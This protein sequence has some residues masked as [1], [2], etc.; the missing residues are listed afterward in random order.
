MPFDIEVIY[1]EFRAETHELLATL[2]SELLAWERSRDA[3]VLHGIFRT[4]HT[5]KGNAQ[6]LGFDALADLA[7]AFEDVLEG[8]RGGALAA[9]APLMALLLTS[10][11]AL[12]N[13]A[14]QAVE[15][16]A[17]GQPVDTGI[18][19]RLRA[20]AGGVVPA[21]DAAIPAPSA[22]TPAAAA[23]TIRVGIGKLDRMMNLTSEITIAFGRLN[24]TLREVGAAENVV[25]TQR[26]T[27]RLFLEMQ[28]ELMKLRMVPVGPVFRQ[29]ERSVRDMA[30]AR[31]KQVRLVLEGENVEIDAAVAEQIKG[32]LTHIL[33]NAIDH[34]IES[35]PFRMASGK[36]PCG[37]LTLRARQA[38]GLMIIEITDNG[39]GLDRN[40]ILSRAKSAKIVADADSLTG[41]QIDELVFRPG[42]STSTGVNG[43]SG[44][45]VGLDVV[46]RQIENLGGTVRIESAHGG[47]T[48]LLLRL[49]LTL[50][51]IAGFGVGVGPDTYIVPL[52]SVLECIDMPASVKPDAAMGVFNL[53]G[54]PVPYAQLR[55]LFAHEGVRP[56]KACI[57]V[58]ERAA[59]P[60]GLV[61][62]RLLGESQV[63]IKPLGPLF[64]SKAAFLGSTILGDGKVGL[65]LDVAG[66]FKPFE[67]QGEPHVQKH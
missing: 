22:E 34:G 40:R 51:I 1:A 43:L 60:A 37:T 39:A 18:L 36:D 28:E 55:K 25:E 65:I 7:H 46:K 27:E 64:Q 58:V 45:G 53:R 59:G 42:F 6:S 17:Q 10:V 62:D 3:N 33:R 14:L 13:Y 54:A 32:P 57:V 56:Q 61:V 41:A 67:R 8:L 19:E 20:A 66:L 52:S 9:G 15:S 38:A 49:P 24:R 23:T 4:A 47:G 5:L 48:T 44:R 29:Y 63:V 50:A 11:D 21:P 31:E 12:R 26:E 35:A 16:G 30:L 2:E